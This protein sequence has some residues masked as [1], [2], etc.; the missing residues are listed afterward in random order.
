MVLGPLQHVRRLVLNLLQEGLKIVANVPRKCAIFLRH[1]NFV[2]V[3]PVENVLPDLMKP[4]W[5][6]ELGLVCA[7]FLMSVEITRLLEVPTAAAPI[8]L[9]VHG[10]IPIVRQ[11]VFMQIGVQGDLVLSSRLVHRPC[12]PVFRYIGD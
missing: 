9:S 2:L 8:F 12:K 5:V 6:H 7:A 1:M 10:G 3:Q 4:A 11:M